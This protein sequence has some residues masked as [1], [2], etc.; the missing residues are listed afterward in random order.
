MKKFEPTHRIGMNLYMKFDGGLYTFSEWTL[1]EACDYSFSDDGDLLFQGK[2]AM[3]K[4]AMRSLYFVTKFVADAYDEMMSD[5]DY[6]LRYDWTDIPLDLKT[7]I[8][9][10]FGEHAAGGLF[11]P[12]P[13]IDHFV[14]L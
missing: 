6:L 5:F 12:Q 1:A 3:G 2:P 8:F 10:V 13:F 14:N 4:P 11:D 9:T 7:R